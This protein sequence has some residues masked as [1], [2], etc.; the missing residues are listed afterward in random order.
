MSKP[1]KH[2]G[3][4]GMLL[5]CTALMTLCGCSAGHDHLA[6]LPKQV[7]IENGFVSALSDDAA[8]GYYQASETELA[9][10]SGMEKLLENDE[11]ALYLGKYYDIAVQSKQTG[12]IWFSNAAIYDET[13]QYQMNDIARAQTFSQL[14]LTY[15]DGAGK[16]FELTSYPDSFDGGEK[17]GV[18]VQRDADT[19]T[20]TYS[21]GYKNLEDIVCSAFSPEDFKKLD[22]IAEA[23]I[24]TGELSSIEYARFTRSY[25]HAE[26]ENMN[27][28]DRRIFLSAFPQLE[29]WGE[30]YVLL[31]P[32]D[33]VKT[34]VAKVSP[35]VG[36]DKAYID[37]EMEKLG[38]EK[39]VVG[40][41]SFFFEIPLTYR[42]DGGDL[43]A[44]IDPTK[45]LDND[46][47]YL[48]RVGFL[49]TFG[50]A[51]PSEDG[52]VLAPDG[53]GAIIENDTVVSGQSYLDI[54]F[55]GTDFCVNYKTGDK[56]APYAP[57]P[58]FGIKA[59]DR[60]IFAIVESGEALG[61]MT[62]Q[63]PD[64]VMPYNAAEPWLTYRVQDRNID[65]ALVYPAKT[66]EEIFSVRYHFL[67]GKDATYS[68]MAQYYQKYLLQTGQLEKRNRKENLP[69]ALQFVCAIDKRQL[70]LGMP[71]DT[72]AAASTF[73]E[74]EAF[75]NRMEQ[76]GV[77]NIDYTLQGAI[78]DGMNF[79][80]PSKVKI[81]KVIGGRKGYDNLVDFFDSI[82]GTL[83][84]GI[85][86][87][88]VY[89]NGNGLD[90]NRQVSRYI[91]REVASISDFEPSAQVKIS[92]HAAYL[93]A[94][95][96]YAG[97]VEDF[98]QNNAKYQNRNIYV[99]SVGSYL[100]SNFK[101][102]AIVD[103]QQ[104]KILIQNALKALQDAGYRITADG[105]NVYVLPYVQQLTDIPVSYG[106]YAIES[107]SVPFVGM[108]L[109]GVMDYSGPALNNR[110]NYQ[111]A[112]LQN[113]ESGA[114]LSYL[115]MTGDPMMLSDTSH[116]DLYN[117]AADYWQE[118]M[119]ETY[120]KL[121]AIF[122]RLSD[123]SIIGHRRP[124][125]N[126]SETTYS[127]G[128]KILVN[129]NNEPVPVDGH[130]IPGQ[131][132]LAV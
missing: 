65:Q 37:A 45:I 112:L 21:F 44:G 6:E 54:P 129:Y 86:F 34:I 52:Y 53:S 56:I 117:I 111:L 50:A 67:Y 107:Y 74:I 63:L 121:N 84:L 8:S 114:G 89:K 26:L 128:T 3:F 9:V 25:K 78:N 76:S 116:S 104:S 102:N 11:A 125:E 113:I 38:I 101:D 90:Q 94:P 5:L 124:V 75:A 93:L 41:D 36:I 46:S 130:T 127:D 82:G 23:K 13:L 85:D 62:A 72:L 69:L 60:S 1:K 28:S 106:N 33:S 31:N 126:V 105:G 57:F 79:R 15:F 110:G 103:R 87:T 42:L 95:Q 32:S 14:S 22:E 59:G 92:E 27:E 73:E 70:V 77:K 120:Q 39:N 109:H 68:G 66:P 99:A 115:L 58:V 18:T 131:G 98:I 81:E 40:T 4:R 96:A 30:L 119:I 17:K 100:S 2:I 47:F 132:W 51:L 80:I 122:S 108:V 48:T 123:C 43:I 49:G 12:S 35:M 16:K 91:G 24:A 118:P 71:M 64:G 97:I 29:E 20:V 55:Y 88:R 83:N 19:V 7:K 61:G 10:L